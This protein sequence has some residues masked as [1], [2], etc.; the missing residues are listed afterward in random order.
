MPE[1]RQNLMGSRIVQRI[2][3]LAAISE[4][5]AALTRICFSPVHRRA[6][7][8]ILSWME[9]AGLAG[10]MDEIGNVI[11]RYE[12]NAPACHP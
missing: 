8:L 2:D 12:G 4:S 11:G 9:E 6:G 5:P 3:A 10:R 7:D 1:A